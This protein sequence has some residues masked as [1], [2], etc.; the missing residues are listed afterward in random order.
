MPA[1]ESRSLCRI[2]SYAKAE[3]D[4]QSRAIDTEKATAERMAGQLERLG[5]KLERAEMYLDRT[6]EWALNDYN[7]KVN[8]NKSIL[9]RVR[10]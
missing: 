9:E 3:L 5:Q 1:S 6:S 7:R 2:P 8:A 10:A 4:R